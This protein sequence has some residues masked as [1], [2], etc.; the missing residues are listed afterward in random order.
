MLFNLVLPTVQ[1]LMD[2]LTALF[3][4]AL[5]QVFFDTA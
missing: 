1:R 5:A 3:H 4:T 2:S